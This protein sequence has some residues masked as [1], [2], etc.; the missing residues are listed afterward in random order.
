MKRILWAIVVL[1][2][3]VPLAAQGFDDPRPIP[4]RDSVF[5]EQLSWMEVRD[6][7]K[8]G[9]TTIIVPTG[10]LEDSG[11][12]LAT[13]KHNY[14]LEGIVE[15]IARRLGNALVAPII[16]LVPQG[17]IN[18][19]SGH[20]RFA[21]T[22]SLTLETYKAML[23]DVCASLKQHGFKDIVLIGDS[24]G[25]QEGQAAVAEKLNREWA[26]TTTRIHHIPEF[27][28]NDEY[29]KYEHDVLGITEGEEGYHDTYYY[30]AMMMVTDPASVHLEER[31][32]AGKT[33]I[34][35][36]SIVPAW[37]T[38]EHGKGLIK[39]RQNIAIAA[40]NKSIAR[41]RSD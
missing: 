27:Y 28:N 39:L 11:P 29:E 33:S 20:M 26:K 40:I 7:I 16:K 9:K 24:H 1:A 5:L 31:I 23:T 37:K 14:N 15:T 30:T 17:D 13:G 35:G 36:V 6:A 19:P 38:I 18:P 25:N 8:A 34:N 12:Y 4:A 22:I 2:F 32:A 41:S 3:T 10:G 21:G